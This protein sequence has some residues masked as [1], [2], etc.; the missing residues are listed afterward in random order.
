MKNFS[1]AFALAVVATTFCSMASAQE[2]S[3]RDQIHIAVQEI[4]PISGQRLGSMGTPIKV[5]VGEETVFLCCKGCLQ[6]QINP[7]HWA[8]IHA[9]FAKAQRICPVMKHDLPENP[10]WTIVEGQIIYVC[11]PPCTKKVAADPKTFLKQIDDLYLASLQ[12]RQRRR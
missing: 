11:C 8:T 2:L 12:A 7:K 1:F 5:K 9:N 4:C 6:K 3:E 10:K